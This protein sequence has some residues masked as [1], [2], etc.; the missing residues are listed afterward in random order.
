M[1]V[2]IDFEQ[3]KGSAK[4]TGSDP[5][6]LTNRGGFPYVK[7]Q[8]A[9]DRAYSLMEQARELTE[10]KGFEDDE[11]DALMNEALEFEIQAIE[12]TGD[13]VK[14]L[15]QIQDAMYL[16]GHRMIGE[17]QSEFE[18]FSE[19]RLMDMLDEMVREAEDQAGASNG[20]STGYTGQ[21]GTEKTQHAERAQEHAKQVR[22][23]AEKLRFVLRSVR[24]IEDL[25]NRLENQ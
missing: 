21:S 9:R 12:F 18:R 17:E 3:H 25:Q 2:Y 7:D 14:D 6:A 15:T 11:V 4:P 8:A 23:N 20:M 19:Q 13:E 1:T 22:E 5:Y 16:F 24:N 10:E